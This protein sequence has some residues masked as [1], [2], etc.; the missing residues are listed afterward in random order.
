MAGAVG[1]G[2]AVLEAGRDQ[3]A[4]G[5]DGGFG[6][7]ERDFP[8]G[9]R[10]ALCGEAL[11]RGVDDLD[12]GGFVD[13]DRGHVGSGLGFGVRLDRLGRGLGEAGDRIVRQ[14]KRLL[15]AHGARVVAVGAG[16]PLGGDGGD[17]LGGGDGGAEAPAVAGAA[18]WRSS[19]PALETST[20]T[21][22]ARTSSATCRSPAVRVLSTTWMTGE[23]R[24]G[25]CARR[26]MPSGRVIRSVVS[27][28]R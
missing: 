25:T 6:F 28:C 18:A 23:M 11:G 17:A 5:L 14:I 27:S 10:A 19:A 13:L 12:V 26:G 15:E 8:E 24:A 3:G 2:H 22:L 21:A 20:A 7:G 1:A 16:A 4:R 9:F